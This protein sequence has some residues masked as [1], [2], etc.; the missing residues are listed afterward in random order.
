MAGRWQSVGDHSGN[1]F[2]P[3]NPSA[4]ARADATASSTRL[5]T[6]VRQG[7]TLE[8]ILCMAM[9]VAQKVLKFCTWFLSQS[10]A[11]ST[12]YNNYV[13]L[14]CIT[15]TSF[16]NFFFFLNFFHPFEASRLVCVWR[17]LGPPPRPPIYCTLLQTS[18]LR[19][20][21]GVNLYTPLFLDNFLFWTNVTPDLKTKTKQ[22]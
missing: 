2:R 21:F 17:V 13:L 7:S 11:P 16:E 15:I 10:V 1:A 8:W 20:R 22:K 4:F 19:Y 9:R 3:E 12:G 14:A 18:P 5:P 6:S